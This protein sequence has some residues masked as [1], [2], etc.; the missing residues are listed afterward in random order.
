MALVMT[1]CTLSC[2]HHIMYCTTMP[3]DILKK[4]GPLQLGLFDAAADISFLSSAAGSGLSDSS[5]EGHK[6]PRGRQGQ[7]SQKQIR[8]DI[9]IK[10]TAVVVNDT[11]FGIFVAE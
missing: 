6:G 11:K 4:L 1:I 7:T 8:T 10:T 3:I 2:T 9:K 5:E